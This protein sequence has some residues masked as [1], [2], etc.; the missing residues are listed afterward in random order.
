MLWE[1]VLA[2]GYMIQYKNSKIKFLQK[3]KTDGQLQLKPFSLNVNNFPNFEE[4]VLHKME[5]KNCLT[6][7]ETMAQ[8]TC[9]EP[10]PI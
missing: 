6:N 7:C 10:S 2:E 4:T 9:Q 5:L 8:V 3:F 1:Y